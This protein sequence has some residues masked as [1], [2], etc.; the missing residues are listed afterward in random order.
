MVKTGSSIMDE[1]LKQAR[2]TNRLLAAQLKS[3]M[4]QME[5]VKLLATSGLSAREIADVLDTSA[6]TVAVT[7]QRLRQKAKKKSTRQSGTDIEE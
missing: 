6:A 4:S 1:L 3:Q 5:L 7:L 2:T